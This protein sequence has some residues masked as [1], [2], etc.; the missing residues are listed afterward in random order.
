MIFLTKA[1]NINVF[2]QKKWS[3]MHFGENPCMNL[4]ILED[5]KNR[6]LIL[7]FHY[8]TSFS[9]RATGMAF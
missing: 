4:E 7:M 3:K 8:T 9:N 5:L 2:W 6:A 1:V